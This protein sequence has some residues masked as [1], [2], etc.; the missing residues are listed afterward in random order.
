MANSTNTKDA[1]ND[2]LGIQDGDKIAALRAQKPILA[3][4]LQAYYESIFEPDVVS[5]AELSPADRC[6]VAVR[7]ASHTR[8]S[9]V[10]GWYAQL[11]RQRGVDE[12]IIDR[13]H[14]I[15]TPWNGNDKLAAAIRHADLLTMA[16]SSARQLDLQALKS[17]GFTPAGIVSLSQVIA[18]VSY[19]LRLIAGLRAFGDAS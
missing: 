18:F 2:I 8:S 19:Q 10:A 6:V 14:D 5:A 13:A 4:Q 17:F 16:P 11:A 12:R 3:D 1:I 15:K 9:A 7:V